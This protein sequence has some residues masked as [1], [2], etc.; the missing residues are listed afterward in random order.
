MVFSD[1]DHVSSYLQIQ[2]PT[3][4]NKVGG[5]DHREALFGVPP[6]GASITQTLYYADSDFCDPTLDNRKGYPKRPLDDS[7]QMEPWPSPFILMMDRGGCSFVRKVRN[8][9]HAGAAGA[10]IADNVC[11]CDDKVC[12]DA[13][14]SDHKCELNKPIMADDGSGGDITIPTVLM[15][16][17]DA[18]SIKTEMIDNDQTIQMQMGWT[19][20]QPDDRV[21]YELWTIPA[22]HVSKDF[23]KDWKHI[24]PK[25]ED[26]IYFTPR[27]YIYDGVKAQ[28][29]IPNGENLCGNLCTNNGKYCAIDPEQDLNNGLS[30]ADMVTESLRRI[31]IWNH[32][33]ESDGIGVEYWDYISAF[34][35]ICDLPEHFTSTR[36]VNDVYK[37]AKID[38]YI[39]ESCMRDSG[40]IIGDDNTLLELEIKK[41]E[42]RNVVVMPTLFV[43][44]IVVRGS[45]TANN[46]INAIC[47]GFLEGTT[48]DICEKCSGCINKKICVQNDGNCARSSSINPGSNNRS[49]HEQIS[50]LQ[51]IVLSSIFGALFY[52]HWKKTREGMRDDVRAIMSEYMPLD[53]GDNEIPTV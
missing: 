8:A 15:L 45:L 44:E 23:Q 17:H 14:D 50:G 34:L 48:P 53:G 29:G 26:H 5:Y 25:F 28:C 10:I 2:I 32:Y 27:Q 42:E 39:I 4:L 37:K 35:D 33:G 49:I 20:P 24:A 16:K 47:A 43:N 7:G 12:L 40:G 13:T 51:I 18:D 41:Q 21:E 1:F 46:V 22:E 19:L 31:C 6:Y 3:T 9:Q 38:S 30:G 52:I 11:V 36:C